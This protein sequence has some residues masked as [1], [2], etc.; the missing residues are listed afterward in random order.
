[1]EWALSK[2]V[3]GGDFLLM[4][5]A[6]PTCSITEVFRFAGHG[7]QRGSATWRDGDANFGRVERICALDSPIFLDDLRRQRVLRTASF[8][9]RN[10]QGRG[11]LVSEYWLYLYSMIYERNPKIRRALVNYAPEKL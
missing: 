2:R 4:Y 5:R 6:W 11:L 3:T 8:V 10:M 7:L 1:M 9:R